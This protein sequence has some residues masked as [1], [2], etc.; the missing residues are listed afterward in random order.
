MSTYQGALICELA[1]WIGRFSACIDIALINFKH[2]NPQVGIK[3]LQDMRNEYE[4][5]RNAEYHKEN[6][7]D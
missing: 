4:A 7:E 2:N 5:Y 1:T 6:A 3:V